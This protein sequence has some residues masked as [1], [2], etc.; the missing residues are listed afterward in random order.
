MYVYDVV[1]V[2]DAQKF[3]EIFEDAKKLMKD[4]L[5]NVSTGMTVDV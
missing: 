1:Y 2:K 4:R 5:Q 3:R